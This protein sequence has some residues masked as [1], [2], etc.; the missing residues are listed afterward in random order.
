MPPHRSHTPLHDT[1]NEHNNPLLTDNAP[2]P[3]SLTKKTRTSWIWGHSKEVKGKHGVSWRCNHCPL[4]IAKVYSDATTSHAI[5]HLHDAHGIAEDGKIS[6]NQTTL[7]TKPQID[8]AVVP[9]FAILDW[10]V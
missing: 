10:I 7:P 4:P 6:T 9:V 1:T 8:P 3:I 5:K 2:T